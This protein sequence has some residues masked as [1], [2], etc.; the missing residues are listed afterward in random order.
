MFGTQNKECFSDMQMLDMI[1]IP[2]SDAEP[3]ALVY[4]LDIILS[5]KRNFAYLTIQKCESNE[6]KCGKPDFTI[7]D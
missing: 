7:Q 5:P 4:L 3:H 1:H 6:Y 2:Y